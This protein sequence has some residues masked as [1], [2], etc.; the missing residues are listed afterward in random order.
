MYVIYSISDHIHLIYIVLVLI[1]QYNSRYQQSLDKF[2]KFKNF[3]QSSFLEKL[4][5]GFVNVEAK[6]LNIITN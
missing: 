5:I 6:V 3:K 1:W 4:I 2:L